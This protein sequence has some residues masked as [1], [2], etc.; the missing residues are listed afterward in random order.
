MA[1]SI[2]AVVLLGI[3]V[4]LLL[5]SRSLSIGSALA[6]IGFGFFL[7]STGLASPIR[8]GLAS[9]TNLIAQITT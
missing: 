4:A 5:R 7:A 9:L 6:A 1:L 3:V 8:H 2:S